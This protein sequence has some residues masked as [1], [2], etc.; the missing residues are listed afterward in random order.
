MKKFF[1][2]SLQNKKKLYF[3]KRLSGL[4][5]KWL[6]TGLQNRLQ[7]FES[8]PDLTQPIVIHCNRFFFDYGQYCFNRVFRLREEHLRQEACAADGL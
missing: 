5:G 4:V 6:S 2:E 1:C 8:A 3:C 7:R